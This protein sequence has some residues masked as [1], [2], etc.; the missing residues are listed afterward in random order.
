MQVLQEF[1]AKGSQLD[2]SKLMVSMTMDFILA[3]M[4]GVDYSTVKVG[5]PRRWFVP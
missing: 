1:A 2:I 5:A 4:F 3:S